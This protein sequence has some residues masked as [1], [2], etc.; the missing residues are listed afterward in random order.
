M[1]TDARP[2]RHRGVGRALLGLAVACAAGAAWFGWQ[3]RNAPDPDQVTLEVETVTAT[4]PP[5]TIAPRSGS[6]V[7][8]VTET[9][10]DTNG[11]TNTD[12]A[13]S[14]D[15]SSTM[16]TSPTTVPLSPLADLL[17]PAGSAIAPV[18]EPRIRPSALVIP[19]IDVL[20]PVRAVG[21]EDD[22]E[23]EVPDETEIGWYQYGATPGD[24]GATVL[25]AHVTWNRTLGPFY[26][27]GELEPGDEVDVVLEDGSTRR[28]AVIERT[29]YDKDG[30]PRDRI[31]RN[32]GPE[33]LVLI[34]CGGSY[35]P[36]IRRYR[37]NIVVYAV[38]V[39]QI[40]AGVS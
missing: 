22:G 1:S 5:S 11:T 37:Q 27:L 32:S 4:A 12:P 9:R 8:A 16:S 14:D 23:L 13:S 28:Y 15:A 34:T 33:S 24:S 2:T 3:A 18:V 30:L 7:D 6:H 36:D 21:L 39:G 10:P 17:G 26:R 20:R 35:N 31:W 25:A 29:I 19:A 40:E 38:P